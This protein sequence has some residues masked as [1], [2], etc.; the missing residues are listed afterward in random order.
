M[1]ALGTVDNIYPALLG[2]E[3]LGESALDA[4]TN[5]GFSL[6]N[7][8]SPVV[9]TPPTEGQIWPRGDFIPF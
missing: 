3:V 8:I 6:L 9:P 2:L 4:A 1:A 7:P 5:L